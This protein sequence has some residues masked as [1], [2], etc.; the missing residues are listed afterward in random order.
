MTA[1]VMTNL[2]ATPAPSRL[3]ARRPTTGHCEGNERSSSKT[4]NST[5]QADNR[6]HAR[7]TS[8]LN[9]AAK[10][11]Q[12]NCAWLVSSFGRSGRLHGTSPDNSTGKKSFLLAENAGILIRQHLA[13]YWFMKTSIFW[14]GGSHVHISRRSAKAIADN[15]CVAI[16]GSFQNLRKLRRALHVSRAPE[17][18]T[19]RRNQHHA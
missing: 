11:G 10:L 12:H 3:R 16:G 2:P 8:S 4:P 5:R 18:Q 1:K 17:K 13:S 14:S 19:T 15:W 6:A 7:A 9:C